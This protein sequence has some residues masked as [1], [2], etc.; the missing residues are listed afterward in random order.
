MH[1]HVELQAQA[2][3]IRSH[4]A[5]GRTGTLPRLFDF[6]LEQSLAGS[7]APFYFMDK[8]AIIA[9]K[10]GDPAA[11]ARWHEQAWRQA[12]AMAGVKPA[13]PSQR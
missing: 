3:T 9:S 8:L 6:L 5:L 4:N 11:A 10:R 2:A 7:H 1:E 12:P 13:A